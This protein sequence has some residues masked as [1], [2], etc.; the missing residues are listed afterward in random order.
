MIASEDNE[1]SIRKSTLALGLFAFAATSIAQTPQNSV[2]AVDKAKIDKISVYISKTAKKLAN[3]KSLNTAMNWPENEEVKTVAGYPDEKRVASLFKLIELQA[4]SE[5][6]AFPKAST[7]QDQAAM[8]FLNR[9]L[10]FSKYQSLIGKSSNDVII[11]DY[12]DGEVADLKMVFSGKIPDGLYLKGS[13]VRKD[14]LN[15]LIMQDK[16][17]AT[18]YITIISDKD[19]RYDTL[20]VKTFVSSLVESCMANMDVCAKLS[21]K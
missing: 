19:P 9:L 8:S 10:T 15:M 11:K 20:A 4:A 12:L 18:E 13:K 14:K 17:V 6:R 7:V 2:S 5:E 16:V 21:E 3:N 1:M